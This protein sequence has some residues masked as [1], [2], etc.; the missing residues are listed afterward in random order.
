MLADNERYFLLMTTF[1]RERHGIIWNIYDYYIRSGVPPPQRTIENGFDSLVAENYSV[2]T[3][4]E[5]PYNR[6][7]D[8]GDFKP[9]GQ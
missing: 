1:H 8:M 2:S 6:K 4:F 7:L 5:Y 3:R 9:M